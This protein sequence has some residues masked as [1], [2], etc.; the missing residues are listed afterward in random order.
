MPVTENMIDSDGYL[1]FCGAYF[2]VEKDDSKGLIDG[3]AYNDT[4]GWDISYN[5]T[6]SSLKNWY[7]YVW[8]PERNTKKQLNSGSFLVGNDLLSFGNSWETDYMFRVDSSPLSLPT[9][10]NGLRVVGYIWYLPD[11]HEVCLK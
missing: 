8:D 5:M 7:G 10:A 6:D 9:S 1:H 4:F 3:F 2:K 11:H